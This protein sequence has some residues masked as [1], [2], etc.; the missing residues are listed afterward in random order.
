M[1]KVWSAIAALVLVVAFL[2]AVLGI[3]LAVRAYNLSLQVHQVYRAGQP[4]I[5][6]PNSVAGL[7]VIAIPR[8]LSIGPVIEGEMEVILPPEVVDADSDF[9]ES[10][11]WEDRCEVT[12]TIWYKDSPVP[13][14]RTW[15][16]CPH[17]GALHVM[18]KPTE[19]LFPTLKK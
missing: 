9:G 12:I 1:S 5:V 17:I 18:F 15:R 13:K 11:R 2:V 16:N 6:D 3:I 7:E 14:Y 4:Y 19:I 8:T 10:G